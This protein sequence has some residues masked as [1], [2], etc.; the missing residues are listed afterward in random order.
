MN[1]TLQCL[2]QV[3]PLNRIFLSRRFLHV[4]NLDNPIGKKGQMAGVYSDLVD[5]LW[6]NIDLL[7]QTAEYT[8]NKEDNEDN[9]VTMI[10]K[11][12]QHPTGMSQ[13]REQM[14]QEKLQSSIQNVYAGAAGSGSGAIFTPKAFKYAIFCFNNQ[15][16]GIEWNNSQELLNWIID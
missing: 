11:W 3:P 15:F 7:Q 6:G 8:Q 9:A 5:R 13:I 4:L 16:E 2:L 14:F 12:D 1:A 10:A